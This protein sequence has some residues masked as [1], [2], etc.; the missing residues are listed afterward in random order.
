MTIAAGRT[1]QFFY[2]A[3]SLQRRFPTVEYVFAVYMMMCSNVYREL[4]DRITDEQRA[5]IA[6]R[7]LAQLGTPYNYL[8]ALQVGWHMRRGLWNPAA[9]VS[10]GRKL[11]CSKVYFDAHIEIAKLPLS[12]CPMTGSVS[13]AHLSATDDLDDVPIPWVRPV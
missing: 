7:A 12:G 8:A 2:T 3:L 5:H 10:Y 11:I 9:L 1:R 6:L 13:P 4:G